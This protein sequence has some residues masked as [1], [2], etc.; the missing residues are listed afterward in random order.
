[1]EL[2]KYR[3]IFTQ[4]SI[5]YLDELD[6]VLLKVEKDLS[7][8]RLWGE[9]HGKLH[10]VKGMARALSM[11][12]LA[13]FCHAM[14]TWCQF[15][16]E[17]AKIPNE[18]VVQLFF[19]GTELLKSF[20]A[21]EGEISA[22]RDLEC[23]RSLTEDLAKDPEALA[24][25]AEPEVRPA[26]AP[27]KIDRIRVD[28]GLIE[29]L[30]A[31]SQEIMRLEKTLPP[32]TQDQISV[33]LGTW[34]NHYI[35]MLKGLYF[36]LAQL[37]LMPVQ[38]F[39]DLFVKTIRDLAKSYN[40]NV[41]LEIEGGEIEVDI[42]LLDRLREPF[43]HLLRNSVAHGIEPSDEREKAGKAG[44]GKIVLRA[45][46]RGDQLILTVSDDGRGLDRDA[47]STYLKEKMGMR[48]GEMEALSNETLLNI[49]CRPDFSSAGET[50]Q[51]A[52]RG[53]GMNVIAQAI[54]YLGGT[55]KLH[56]EPSKGTRFVIL[57]PLS[58]SIIYAV[59]FRLGKYVLAIPTS[60]V[61]AIENE[62]TDP[63]HK[64]SQLCD[65]GSLLG[66]DNENKGR[67]G[68]HII[69][70]RQPAT[71][72]MPFPEDGGLGIAADAILGNMPLMA[73]PLGE[74]L[75][76]TGLFAGVGIMENGDISLILDIEKLHAVAA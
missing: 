8:R 74:L 60:H 65:L 61:H 52:G 59:L 36:Q 75:A 63:S 53:I 58:L 48:H 45:E 9:I 49:I 39:G 21:G 1:M 73:I 40:R 28:Y 54:E 70:L 55:M 67:G 31:R 3:K 44:T 56:S 4:E 35:S 20:V 64:V 30:L 66:M 57:L 7:D 62:D 47:I 69:R 43:M 38:D 34:I 76:K 42:G 18:R 13:S 2:E 72:H 14:E 11:M 5:K 10:S 32:L 15:F 51:L 24:D 41:K 12:D 33:G 71:S 46:R 50:T 68:R 25:R 6:A 23:L 29:S 17:G 27:A 22:P 19:D 37:R 26:I 16:Q